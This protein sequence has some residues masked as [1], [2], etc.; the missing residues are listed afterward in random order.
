MRTITF[1]LSAALIFSSI[2]YAQTSAPPRPAA[3][4]KPD[5]NSPSNI[6]RTQLANYLDNIAA[7]E[8]TQRR[9]TIARIT[10]RAQAEARQAEVRQKVLTLIGGLPDKTPLNAKS[11]GVTQAEGFRIE[12]ILFESQPN[13]PV[14]ALLYLPDAK[15]GTQAQKLPAIVVAPGHGPTG[16][17]SDYAFASLFARN[18]FAVLSYD[19][20]GQGERLQYPDPA[21]PDTSL[22]LRP[23]GEHGEAGL[24]PT[25]IGDAIARYFAW[26]GIRAVDY[27]QSRP[28]IDPN[29]IGA[30]GCSG[31]GTATAL[32][33]AL[34]PRVKAIGTACY[35]TSFDTLLPAIGPQDA[36]QSIPNFIASGLDLPDWVE[37]AAPRLY[38][39]ISTA[40]DMFP[41]AGARASVTEARRFYSLF[42]PAS[43]G[44]PTGAP[45]PGTPTAPTLNPDT[46]NTIPPTAA[47]QWIT[48][49][50]GHGNLRPLQSQIV[51]FF[52]THLANSTAAPILP[53]PPP[54]GASPFALP[55]GISKG[56]FQVTPTGQV[57]TSYPGSETVHT[58]NLKRFA[59]LPKLK[60]QTPTQL[61]Q[62]VR[63]VAH[64]TVNPGDPAPINTQS[65]PLASPPEGDVHVRHRF[66]LATA[67]G[68]EIQ[69][70]FYRPA[71]GKH[72][73]LLILKDS[74]DPAL[75]PSRV[76]EIKSLRALADAGTAVLVVAPRPSP[77]GTEETKATLLGPFYLTELRSELVGKTLLG[78]RVDDVIAAVNFMQGSTTGDPNQIT[79]QASG[80]LGLVLLHAA[81]LDSRLKHITIDY[82]LESYKSLLEAPMPIGAP[83]D[84]LPGVVRHYDIPDLVRELG[85]RLTSKDPIPGSANLNSPPN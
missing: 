27:L 19:P 55:A 2:A 40:S 8:L 48:G 64:V 44:T 21:K 84:I 14:T 66:T 4:T 79:A 42:D 11:L 72:P 32:L 49:I 26:D 83:E 56:A 17:T 85:P 12:K 58:L 78:L 68:I 22:A 3:I 6:G 60:P 45:Q 37:L 36:E 76:E 63:E 82:V 54:P 50:G 15:P 61:Q 46:S 5:P 69:A 59:A 77:P 24:Q 43:A 52:L 67:P 65:P 28:E 31:G 34:D 81:V 73:M 18:G 71:D 1:L 30:F 35:I 74:L 20:I 10:T 47:L 53:P 51:Q 25:L 75:E 7:E 41:Y 70:E 9:A 16:K 39:V 57:S 38:A 29:R 80:H 13:F 23:T 33:G 62:S